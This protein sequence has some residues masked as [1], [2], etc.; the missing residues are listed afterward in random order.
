MVFQAIDTQLVLDSVNRFA[1]ANSIQLDLKYHGKGIYKGQFG[2]TIEGP[3]GSPIRP[4][5]F[6]RNINDGGH[7]FMIGVGLYRFVCANGLVV[8]ESFYNQRIIHR[9]GPTMNDFL[10]NLDNRLNNAFQIAAEDFTDSI[11]SLQQK[12]LTDNQGLA[13]IG[14]LGLP[15]GIEQ[16]SQHYWLNP[17]RI[18]EQPRNLWTLYNVVNE[19]NRKR[20]NAVNVEMN[21]E[22]SLLQ[23]I[24]L[25]YDHEQYL[26]RVAA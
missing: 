10:M 11:V 8:G 3:D 16:Y 15:Q 19:M 13:I 6:L 7:A 4:M 26:A 24:E 1:N 9:E 5:L 12:E 22:L 18:S 2:E 17:Q 23:N 20:S 25:L 14:S 21:R